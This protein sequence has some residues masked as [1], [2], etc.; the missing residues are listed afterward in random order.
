MPTPKRRFLWR[1]QCAQFP[2]I[3]IGP[4]KRLRIVQP[5]H[6]Y[7][8][9]LIISKRRLVFLTDLNLTI[10]HDHEVLGQ[11]TRTALTAVGFKEMP[12]DTTLNP[13]LMSCL[14]IGFDVVSFTVVVSIKDAFKNLAINRFHFLK[15][16]PFLLLVPNKFLKRHRR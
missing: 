2:F 8:D 3:P 5:C 7:A 15:N 12:S 11:I 13:V 6:L 4:R 14:E 9:R 10:Q 1:I 16:K